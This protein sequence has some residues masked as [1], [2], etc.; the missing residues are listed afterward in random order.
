MRWGSFRPA[1]WVVRALVV[2]AWTRSGIG[3]GAARGG[4]QGRHQRQGRD[5]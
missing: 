5:L 3:P 4:M 1:A 2:V